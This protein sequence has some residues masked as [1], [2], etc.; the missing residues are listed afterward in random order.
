MQIPGDQRMKRWQTKVILR[1]AL[2]T[3]VPPAIMSRS[4]MGF[5]VP[6][7]SWLRGAFRTMVDEYVLSSRVFDRCLFRPDTVRRIAE[8]HMSGSR[9]HT[10]RLWLLINLEMWQ[11]MAIEGEEPERLEEHMESEGVA[12]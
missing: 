9:N 10:D 1:E 4:K 12:V 6:V 5:P 3:L 8:E 7:G 11:R 2:R